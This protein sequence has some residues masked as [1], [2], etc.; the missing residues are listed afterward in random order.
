LI[1][2]N[3]SHQGAVPIQITTIGL[4]IAKNVFQVHGIDAAEL[5]VRKVEA[6]APPTGEVSVGHTTSRTQTV[7]GRGGGGRQQDGA[8][9]LGVVGR[10]RQLSGACACGSGVRLPPFVAEFPGSHIVDGAVGFFDAT[11]VVHQNLGRSQRK[12][13]GAPHTAR[14]ACD[15]GGFS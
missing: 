14:N 4:D 8:R 7:Q 11:T 2:V 6:G 5:V 9:C 15:E 13:A 10:G 1:V 12:R 3:A